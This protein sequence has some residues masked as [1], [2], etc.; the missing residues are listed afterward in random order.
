MVQLFKDLYSWIINIAWNKK[1]KK[2]VKMPS[3]QLAV[4]RARFVDYTPGNITALAFS[5]QSSLKNKLT[6]S[7]LRLAIGR[8]N[9]D[10]E[11]WNPRNN[12][13]QEFLIHG[14]K[15]RSIE[16]L[17]WSNVPGEPLRLFSI[18]G[19]TVVTEW[20]LATG[21][22]LKNY[23]CNAGV[24]WSIAIN[25][26]QDKLAVGC[27]N[28]TV[29]IIDISGGPGVLEHDI[30][31][32]RQECRILSITWNDDNYVIGGGSD[33]RIRI[34]NAMNN[35]NNS[36]ERGKLLHSMKVDKAKHESTLVWSVLYLPLKNQIVSGD[37]TGSVKFWDFQYATLLQSFHPHNADV[38]CLTTD[39]TNTNVFSAGVDRKIFQFSYHASKKWINSSNRLLHGN[40][41]RCIAS[42]QSHGAD[43]LISGG[44]EKSFVIT[45]LSSFAHGNYRKMPLINPYSKNVLINQAQRYVVM[46]GDNQTIKIWKVGEMN[47]DTNIENNYKLVCKMVLKGEENITTCDMSPDGQ[48][49]IVGRYSNTKVFFLQPVNDGSK[50]KVTKLDNNL[51]LKTG[52]KLIKFVDNSRV[53]ICTPDDTLFKLDL[54]SDNDEEMID[55]EISDLPN[56]KSSFKIP[57]LN[58]I[59]HLDICQDYAIVSR[60]CG[61]VDVISLT[62]GHYKSLIRLMNSITVIKINE[63]KSTVIIMTADNK[64]Y[65]L[66]VNID[67]LNNETNKSLEDE[68]SDHSDNEKDDSTNDECTKKKEE[69]EEEGSEDNDVEMEEINKQEES[70]F[71]QWSKNNI[72][73]LPKRIRMLREKCNGIF[74][75][76]EDPN[77]VWFWGSTWISRLDFSIDLPLINRKKSKKRSHEGL[78]ITDGGNF[79]DSKQTNE[80]D[81]ED[82]DED[83]DIE[84]AHDHY[85]HSHNDIFPHSIKNDKTDQNRAKSESQ[86]FYF[87]DKYKPNLCVDFV[88]K[89]ELI[90]VERPMAMIKASK[91]FDLPK[92]VF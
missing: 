79:M 33:G 55:L 69:E 51:L 59:N 22:P 91:A 16:G 63:A 92:I 4:H 36:H 81:E 28:G 47:D 52:S 15:G 44:L 70:V 9:G 60:G 75:D 30:I 61:A 23:D 2:M 83:M 37:S 43:F 57:Y 24:I 58:K 68:L 17:C 6:P 35:N 53:V 48:V 14:G 8:S 86:V 67:S 38:L 3:Q 89:N 41:I 62:T 13:V 32:T 27:D 88:S 76:E 46:W 90:T 77:L 73:N 42:Y 50:L 40:D 65:E 25:K 26:S 29:V 64:I 72:D 11:I 85:S 20:N 18:G 34:W 49:L 82:E 71:T 56:T 74:I 1:K 87:N 21:L 66:N 5:H 19:S 12:W 80:E 78:T 45:S 84:N 31:L 7:D 54:E 39:A 10:I